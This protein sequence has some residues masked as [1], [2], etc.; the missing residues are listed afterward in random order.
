MDMSG[1]GKL[2]CFSAG[3]DIKEYAEG[4]RLFELRRGTGTGRE[5]KASLFFFLAMG[6]LF[7]LMLESFNIVKLPVCAIIFL[8]CMYMCGYYI[9]FLPKRARQ[10]GERIY[11]SSGFLSLEYRYEFYRE[12][13]VM[14]NKNH[15]I[16]R[17][18][19]ELSDCI[20]TDEIFLLIGTNE[21]RVTVIQKSFLDK[22]TAEKLSFLLSKK[23]IKQYRDIRKK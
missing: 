2:V 10:R 1:P 18:F 21:N 14:K 7:M 6:M 3:L 13:F 8:I 22:E 15:I 16:K 20:E 4:Y 19:T 23:T 11:E 9:F 17:Y 12:Y 5:I